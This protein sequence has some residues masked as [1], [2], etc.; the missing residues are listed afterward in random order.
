MKGRKKVNSLDN[1]FSVYE[2][3]LGSWKRNV[4]ENRSMSY[5][6]LATELVNYVKEMNF[7]HVEFMPIMEYP[8]D[9]SWGYQ[10][11]G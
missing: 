11:I 6:E 10:L 2:L 5:L 1:A 9:P 4:A 3:H 8:F 7:T